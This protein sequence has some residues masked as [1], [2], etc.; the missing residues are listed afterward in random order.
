MSD[1][2]DG[3]GREIGSEID[4][5]A[6]DSPA[7]TPGERA[8]RDGRA[9]PWPTGGRRKKRNRWYFGHPR[10][11]IV[12]YPKTG[13]NLRCEH[14]KFISVC[15]I[16]NNHPLSEHRVHA[17]RREQCRPVIQKQVT[18]EVT[19]NEVGCQTDT[20]LLIRTSAAA[21]KEREVCGGSWNMPRNVHNVAAYL[22]GLEHGQSQMADE[23]FRN[24]E[25]RRAYQKGYSAGSARGMKKS[26]HT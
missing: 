12:R 8:V 18:K 26:T 10:L 2:D 24:N 7:L 15:S 25:L 17:T 6:D 19:T 14:D 21:A 20:M 1:S 5:D 3:S 13:Y 16:C 9:K 4:Y 22:Q 23:I 11:G